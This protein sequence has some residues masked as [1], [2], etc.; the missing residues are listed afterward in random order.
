MSD[1]LVAT[2][3]QKRRFSKSA[4]SEMYYRTDDLDPT[5]VEA[6]DEIDRL[7]DR[8]K[9]LEEALRQIA[10]QNCE[11]TTGEDHARAIWIA[12]AAL[13]IKP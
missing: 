3:A 4:T 8:V 13:E 2:L 1:S 11:S 5:C 7:R 12:R 10:F 6:A 9:A